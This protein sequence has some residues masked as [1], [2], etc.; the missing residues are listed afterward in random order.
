V[1]LYRWDLFWF[2]NVRD[3]RE[4]GMSQK[5]SKSAKVAFIILSF[6]SKF[7]DIL[8]YSS[9][10]CYKDNYSSTKTIQRL[11]GD[12]IFGLKDFRS[13][14]FWFWDFC[15]WTFD[16]HPAKEILRIKNWGT[17]VLRA[18]KVLL[19]M[20]VR[21]TKVLLVAKVWEEKSREQK[22]AWEQN[23]GEQKFSWDQKS[24]E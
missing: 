15:S 18:T 16:I 6:N 20:K 11:I 24:S 8:P 21:G 1:T 3:R 5:W 17:K 23:S 12:T 10:N 22:S 14:D 13:P 7:R 19:G 2:R 4:V 9:F